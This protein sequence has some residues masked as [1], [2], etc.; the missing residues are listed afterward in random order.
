MPKQTNQFIIEAPK[1]Y[2]GR[3]LIL[4]MLDEK[5]FGDLKSTNTKPQFG[6]TYLQTN[7]N[8]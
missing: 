3:Y 2:L 6:F 1:L 8:I 5:Y 4:S 7:Y